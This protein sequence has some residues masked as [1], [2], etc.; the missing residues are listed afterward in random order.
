MSNGGPVRDS[1]VMLIAD[2]PGFA[3]DLIARWQ[4]EC[5][6]PGITVMNTDLLTGT[7][8]GNLGP[9]GFELAGFD[10]IIMGPVRNKRMAAVLKM[11]N[12]GDYP[13]ICLLENAVDV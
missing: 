7:T 6:L 8:E 12:A 1:Q 9:A 10:L 5:T 2:D 13:V 11:V 3:R 4:A